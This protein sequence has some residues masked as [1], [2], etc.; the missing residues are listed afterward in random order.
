MSAGHKSDIRVRNFCRLGRL[1]KVGVIEDVKVMITGVAQ[2]SSMMAI[3]DAHYES[4]ITTE[5]SK[6]AMKITRFRFRAGKETVAGHFTT[7][8]DRCL[9]HIVRMHYSWLNRVVDLE[10]FIV[11]SLKSSFLYL[12]LNII[13]P[14]CLS[15]R[16]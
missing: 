12:Y 11:D 13:A 3:R 7:S 5:F 1:R 16:F 10:S 15:L 8:I 4:D 2:V 6:I 9:A 14:S